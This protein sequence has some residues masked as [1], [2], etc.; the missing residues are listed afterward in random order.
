MK[1][2]IPPTEFQLGILSGVLGTIISNAITILLKIRLRL[3]E[4]RE[5]EAKAFPWSRALSV[6]VAWPF[7]YD[8]NIRQISE[9]GTT[10]STQIPGRSSKHKSVHGCSLTACSGNY[11]GTFNTTKSSHVS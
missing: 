3:C 9:N 10:T 8:G 2:T 1:T 5:Q 6:T 7:G 11:A 4:C